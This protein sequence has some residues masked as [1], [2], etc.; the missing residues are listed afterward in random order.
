[1]TRHRWRQEKI[2][3]FSR[4]YLRSKVRTHFVPFLWPLCL[5]IC[6]LYWL[7]HMWNA[8]FQT[9][10]KYT[11]KLSIWNIIHGCILQNKNSTCEKTFMCHAR[12]FDSPW[13][14]LHW[15]RFG[16]FVQGIDFIQLDYCIFLLKLRPF[17]KLQQ[18]F[19]YYCKTRWHFI[20]Q[21]SLTLTLS[22]RVAT[23]KPWKQQIVPV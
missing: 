6:Y 17:I 13:Q 9:L 2:F 23:E 19:Q 21:Y 20:L 22:P 4:G 1:M 10:L 3:S 12:K 11:N 18:Y 14:V 5:L 16:V 8:T 7:R 15:K